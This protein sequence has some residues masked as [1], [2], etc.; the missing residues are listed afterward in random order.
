MKIC[1]CVAHV[2]S[3]KFPHRLCL[4]GLHI[5]CL[6][7]WDDRDKMFSE[8]EAIIKRQISVRISVF[9]VTFYFL[10]INMLAS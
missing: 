2:R 4:F 1:L 10:P 6:C 3:F 5:Q 9:L 8:V 7:S